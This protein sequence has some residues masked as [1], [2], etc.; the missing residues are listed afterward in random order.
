[1]LP[2]P[3]LICGRRRILPRRPSPSTASAS[4]SIPARSRCD[5]CKV[6][7]KETD[8]FSGARWYAPSARCR[9]RAP[10][11]CTRCKFLFISC[12]LVCRSEN[13]WLWLGADTSDLCQGKAILSAAIPREDD[14][15]GLGVLCR[16]YTFPR[17]SGTPSPA[18]HRAHRPPPPLLGRLYGE[19]HDSSTAVLHVDASFTWKGRT[20]FIL[21]TRRAEET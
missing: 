13:R 18:C 1:M 7:K 4:S 10:S 9:L 12:F 8:T 11:A 15:R 2:L 3:S 21:C 5:A 17:I 16:C 6:D 20:R 19:F 14:A